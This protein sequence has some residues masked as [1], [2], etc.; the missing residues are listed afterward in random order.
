MSAGDHYELW[1][2]YSDTPGYESICGAYYGH[3]S[4]FGKL[5]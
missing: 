3:D 2:N 5:I 4:I 1:Q